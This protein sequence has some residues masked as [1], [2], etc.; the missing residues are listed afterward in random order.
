VP[1]ELFGELWRAN[2]DTMNI[3][4]VNVVVLYQVSLYFEIFIFI[5]VL[6]PE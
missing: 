3:V 2:P 1:L 5:S 4:D 6:L